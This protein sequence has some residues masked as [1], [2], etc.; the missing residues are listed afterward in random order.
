M[1]FFNRINSLDYVDLYIYDDSETQI[2]L[3]TKTF[4]PNR[5]GYY[6]LDIVINDGNG[7]SLTVKV[8]YYVDKKIVLI[9]PIANE[10]YYGQNDTTFDYCVY[11][12]T[13]NHTNERFSSDPY[14]NI[15]IFT[16]VYCTKETNSVSGSEAD[17]LGANAST[18]S[19][20]GALSRIESSWY[21]K[22]LNNTLT[23]TNEG[24]EEVTVGVENN[25]VGNYNLI[26]G[27][28]N[29][30]VDSNGAKDDNYIV[31]IHKT[32]RTDYIYQTKDKVM[33]T[34]ANKE[35]I[36]SNSIN[37]APLDD[38]D[39]FAQSNVMFTI[40]QILLEVNANG[41]SK[42]YGEVDTNKDNYNDD[43]ASDKYLSGY[44]VN[45]DTLINDGVQYTDT[46]NIVLGVLRRE[47]GENVGL[48]SI[49]NYRG[50]INDSVADTYDMLVGCE[51]VDPEIEFAE[52]VTDYD[53]YDYTY[54]NG[55]LKMNGAYIKSRALYVA[56]NKSVAGRTMN[57]TE[58]ARNNT[59]ANYV[60]KYTGAK[61]KIDPIDL[62]VQA[63]PG[64][65]REYNANTSYSTDPNPWEI[66]LY[67][68]KE[69]YKVATSGFNGYTASASDYS[70]TIKTLNVCGEI[71]DI[72]DATTES[73]YQALLATNQSE[74][75]DNWYFMN[76]EDKLSGLKTNESYSLLRNVTSNSEA[77]SGKLVREEGRDGGWYDYYSLANDIQVGATASNEG[78]TLA[79]ITNGMD[80]CVYDST[81]HLF[82]VS[83]DGESLCKNYE[84]KYNAYYTD[85]NGFRYDNKEAEKEDSNYIYKSTGLSSEFTC[86]NLDPDLPCYS[87]SIDG[88]DSEKQYR[89]TFEIY[90]R[91]II[92]EFNSGIENIKV[93]NATDEEINLEEVMYGKRYGFYNTNY[94]SMEYYY[95]DNTTLKGDSIG[96]ITP[97]DY[98]FYCYQ[99]MSWTDSGY[100]EG[101]PTGTGCTGNPRYGLT[102]G[103]TWK[104]IGLA[105]K[106]HD[107]V[108]GGYTSESG[109]AIPAGVYFVYAS[110]AEAQTRNYN[111]KYQGGTLTIK[112]KPVDIAI[113]SYM[114]E[115]GEPNYSKYGDGTDFSDM[116]E[117]CVFDDS[118]IIS[119]ESETTL[120]SV[121]CMDENNGISNKYAFYIANNGL[122]EVDSIKDNFKGRPDRDRS[123]SLSTDT[124]GLQDNVGIYKITKGT[125]QASNVNPFLANSSCALTA[126]PESTCVVVSGNAY[127]IENYVTLGEE[128]EYVYDLV[129][130]SNDK[131]VVYH[132]GEIKNEDKEEKHSYIDLKDLASVTEGS[133]FITPATL[134][135]TVTSNQTKMF[136]CAYNQYALTPSYTYGGGYANCVDDDGD[137]YDLGYRYLVSGDKD[138]QIANNGFNYSSDDSYT[139]DGNSRP[140]TIGE[141]NGIK[142]HAL[143]DGVL[144]R[145]ARNTTNEGLVKN[146]QFGFV[147]NAN[148]SGG[149]TQGQTVGNYIITLGSVNAT[150]NQSGATYKNTCDSSNNPTVGGTSACRN[151]NINYYNEQLSKYD[152]TEDNPFPTDLLF[153]ISSRTVYMYTDYDSK[154]Y[155]EADPEIEYTCTETDVTNRLCASTGEEIN[156]GITK[157]YA[158]VNSLAKAPWNGE[159]TTSDYQ[160]KVVTG[161]ISRKGMGENNPA[162]DDVKGYY[163]YRYADKG[164]TVAL[165]EYGLSNYEINFYEK[166][167]DDNELAVNAAGEFESQITVDEVTDTYP[168][169]FE[170]VLRRIKIKFISFNKIYGESDV[171]TDYD[172]LVCA[173][174]QEFV[175]NANGT[176]KCG[177][178]DPNERHGL[179]ATH[180]EEYINEGGDNWL[181]DAK[182]EK[183]KTDFMVRY[184]RVLG[185]N[186]SCGTSDSI[187]VKLTGNFFGTGIVEGSD[188]TEF[189]VTLQC[190][191]ETIDEEQKKVYQTLAYIDQSLSTL[192]G[193]NYEASYEI[194][195]VNIIPRPIVITPD[196]NQG[197]EYGNYHGS[198]IPAITF[199]DGVKEDVGA[200]KTYG[201]V[202]NGA[203]GG[204]C[205]KN[206]DYYNN[207]ADAGTCFVINDRQNEYDAY[208]GMTT[209][210]TNPTINTKYGI[211]S[212][213]GDG[214]VTYD[215]NKKNYVFEDVYATESSTRTALNR[216]LNSD[217][218]ARY[219][220]NVGEYTITLGELGT[221]TFA[222][223]TIE[224]TTSANNLKYEITAADVSVTPVSD[225]S[226]IYGEADEE[227]KFEVI[228][229]Y[230]VKETYYLKWNEYITH[231]YDFDEVLSEWKDKTA[232]TKNMYNW[233]G[234]SFVEATYGSFTYILIEK[235]DKIR[236]KGFAYSENT[237]D[238]SLNYGLNKDGQKLVGEELAQASVT[239]AKF[240]DKY[241]RGIQSGT[242]CNENVITYLNSYKTTRILLGY[243][244]VSGYN[245]SAGVYSIKNGF[246]V[247]NNEFGNKNYNLTVNEEVEYTIIPR[248]VGVNV[249]DLTK[250]YGEATDNS[251]CDEATGCEGII[252]SIFTYFTV[253]GNEANQLQLKDTGIDS[254]LGTN[255]DLYMNGENLINGLPIAYASKYYTP[256]GSA[257]GNGALKVYVSRDELNAN[258]SCMYAN[259]PNGMC[260]DVGTYALRLYGY[261]NTIDTLEYRPAQETLVATSSV[262]SYYYNMYFDYNPNY[263]VVVIDK[264]N[265][266]VTSSNLKETENQI[267]TARDNTVTTELLKSTGVLTI[268]KKEVAIYVNTHFIDNATQTEIYYIEQNTNPPV[269]PGLDNESNLDYVTFTTN[270]AEA[271][272][273]STYGNAI[274]GNHNTGVRTG[275]KLDG[276]LAY[277]NTILTE[278]EFKNN[279]LTPGITASNTYDCSDLLYDS[280]KNDLNTN[281]PGYV[282]IIRDITKLSI[283]NTS[284]VADGTYESANYDV[285]FYP[286]ALRIEI[287]DTKPVVEVNR[288]DVYIEANAVGQYSY[289]CVGK[290]G[291]TTY[292]D[293]EGLNIIGSMDQEA[294]DAILKW[295]KTDGRDVINTISEGNT[296]SVIAGALPK[297]ENCDS[298]EYECT[299]S[300][301]FQLMYGKGNANF[302]SNGGIKTGE[303]ATH[304]SP[305]TIQTATV[306]N[307]TPH[308]RNELINSFVNWFGVTAYDLGEIRNGQALNKVFDKYW[309]MIIEN[310]GVDSEGTEVQ[311]EINKV[312]SYR[313]H[314]YVMDNAGNVSQGNS[315]EAYYEIKVSNRYNLVNG[316]Y[317]Q[318]NA[319]NYLKVASYLQIV[320]ENLY[321][322]DESGNYTQNDE[323][324]YLLSSGN[325]YD[326]YAYKRFEKT[327]NDYI[328][329]NEGDYLELHASYYSIANDKVYTKNGDGSYTASGTVA[330]G[331]YLRVGADY[332]NTA[333]LHIIDTT[334]P[335]VGTL[336]LY[337]G[338]VSC[339]EGDCSKEENWLVAQDTFVPINTL[340]RYNSDGTDYSG[341]GDEYVEIGSGSLVKLSTLTKYDVN[342]VAI[343]NNVVAGAKYIKIIG[344]LDANGNAKA[345]AETPA[346]AIALKHYTWTNQ[347]IYL[348]ITG[349]SDN[350]YTDSA[351]RQGID[352][353]DWA[354]DN[355]QWDHYYSRDGGITWFLYS[356]TG[357]GGI[358]ALA[359]EGRREIMIKAVDKGVKLTSDKSAG[360]YEGTKSYIDKFY[361][362]GNENN[363]TGT[364]TIYKFTDSSA[365][366]KFLYELESA[367]V[368]DMTEEIVDKRYSVI[369]SDNFGW[370]VSDAAEEDKG[371]ANK[372][373]KLIYGIKANEEQGDPADTEYSGYTY[374][375]DKK[376]AYYDITK[377]VVSIGGS[378]GEKLYLF[379]YGC[380]TLD[381]CKK[382]YTEYY[383]TVGDTLGRTNRDS[384]NSD[385]DIELST[386]ILIDKKLQGN[387]SQYEDFVEGIYTILVNETLNTEEFH[388]GLSDK[389]YSMQGTNAQ[390]SIQNIYQED[391]IYVIYEFK[392]GSNT[393][394]DYDRSATMTNDVIPSTT[395]DYSGG[396]VTYTVV[397]SVVDK[398]GNESQYIARGVIFADLVPYIE[399]N[400]SEVETV[401]A[402]EQIDDQ[403]YYLNVEQGTDVKDI[404]RS[405]SV[406]ANVKSSYLTQTV[407]Y[408]GELVLDNV[409]YNPNVYDGFNTDNPGVYEITYNLQYRYYGENGES[410]MISAEPLKLVVNVESTAPIS[411]SSNSV[412]YQNIILLIS[413]LAGAMF[414]VMLGVL[415]KKRI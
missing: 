105:F 65:R 405:L 12:D 222:N 184:K 86:M 289:D 305:F 95:S 331:S 281:L 248:P 175:Q 296:V 408:N 228:T 285:T 223:Y 60:I 152:G 100:D 101:N 221:K 116:P 214:T 3:K 7:N 146:N 73:C 202:N 367:N 178:A 372:I 209:S 229:E 307:S 96:G 362:V 103:D 321:D 323:G 78:S 273:T 342:K 91:E 174:S 269:L 219:N 380:S 193:Y 197:F 247:A 383:A 230:D 1:K 357:S 366:N 354:I 302:N 356:R 19:F 148:A 378:N 157:Y 379:E 297:I 397:Y 162:T 353:D 61:Y 236:L 327:G 355:S 113:T 163:E 242:E 341:T 22:V 333:T 136:G 185:E 322:K 5:T 29:I 46:T 156:F 151:Y 329:N 56:T 371:Q 13:G 128:R 137:Y 280:D 386:S 81:G 68:L 24:G 277:C 316:N 93:W 69:S 309:F 343:T 415:G 391:R 99:D 57:S 268:D 41:G 155:G 51:V 21:N 198:L 246:K 88:E 124:N 314:F 64:Q 211:A 159:D 54:E 150:E 205:L 15:D 82:T 402:L 50:D 161:K 240:Y 39:T 153:S 11:I 244:F 42:S 288:S 111:F 257:E 208:S 220:R 326:T 410:E 138:Y 310:L 304:V 191:Q 291:T 272:G 47:V 377:P 375:R 142:A 182:L 403:T 216:T 414:I 264:N 284:T 396:D 144:Y 290:T 117:N 83:E 140:S 53:S 351:S 92:L 10:K 74:N 98:L 177:E 250:T 210:Y 369:T 120:I 339:N 33:I 404:V 395:E 112:S 40:K 401:N 196:A 145:V 126:T 109:K 276:Q 160:T 267:T 132:S 232:H 217:T 252:D 114:K 239:G 45:S 390:T 149:K 381:S 27:N 104:K 330:N 334:A 23:Y 25:Y 335:T 30:T 320:K 394:V 55:I 393:R 97:E 271:V 71:T 203:D 6:D 183:F 384:Q 294:E 37:D 207:G 336:N 266:A 243:V 215:Y 169:K 176:W 237:G 255:K 374:Y 72:D 345:T 188:G 75:R 131:S 192:P 32:Y 180:K 80:N 352:T 173:P 168:V 368:S 58:D 295:L 256:S 317:I 200:V 400:Q 212:V 412:N 279:L 94:F 300:A 129:G 85:I 260:E 261:G 231:V 324:R 28:L 306:D 249:N 34:E 164:G 123:V 413:L 318:D 49:C 43:D 407:Y 14:S 218:D 189:E 275:D 165:T 409:R 364:K 108:S 399:V 179:S 349:G 206:I 298:T 245:Q 319:G 263:F 325:Y 171:V 141:G 392:D 90:R 181:S 227:L 274:W 360:D 233:N 70:A 226:K 315:K 52:T 363:T 370:N 235:G 270:R 44:T 16:P 143:N 286:G 76:G 119:G 238:P 225:Q 20:T 110:I 348:T 186:V 17:V 308:T 411:E 107:S 2:D 358:L 332:N 26:L 187:T 251:S 254:I 376:Y 312:G 359:Q 328:L 388:S 337:N 125:I 9:A 158:K 398:A 350:S 147:T 38:D 406:D 346:K 373:S 18:S 265:K 262:S 67:G 166:D 292:S 62:I 287:D 79:V 385:D 199:A 127:Q 35:S 338:K 87:S 340:L 301:L 77:G 347:D 234:S 122:D 213:A 84:L 4:T 121:S 195:Y 282:P 201:L 204:V 63:A 36:G 387:A 365:D 139:V 31:K 311:F 190:K 106:L 118:N 344:V 170:I 59:R 115:Y 134:T 259:D 48:Y 253:L 224:L 89:I 130:T 293:C 258:G 172:I 154:V 313:V 135:I 66:I 8:S 102:D 278:A 389:R 133:L 194:G 303:E 299:A 361:G 382:G 167:N 241:C 283:V